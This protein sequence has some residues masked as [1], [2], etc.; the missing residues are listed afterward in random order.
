MLPTRRSQN[1]AVVQPG[2][3]R[4]WTASEIGLWFIERTSSATGN[5]K[6]LSELPPGVVIPAKAGI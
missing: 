6:E 1:I 4:N 2:Y 5:A 3:S